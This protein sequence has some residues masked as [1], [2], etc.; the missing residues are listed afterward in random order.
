MLLG[1]LIENV[2]ITSRLFSRISNEAIDSTK[3]RHLILST[4]TI[5]TSPILYIVQEILLK[6][7]I[8]V[9]FVILLHTLPLLST[10]SLLNLSIF[11]LVYKYLTLS[12]Y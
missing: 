5:S 12:I 4:T 6:F 10:H 9:I 11:F 7:V 1:L 8:F 2:A 3:E